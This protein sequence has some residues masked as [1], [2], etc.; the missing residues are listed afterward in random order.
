MAPGEAQA[1]QRQLLRAAVALVVIV[2]VAYWPSLRHDF[3]RLD[4][5]QYVVDNEVVRH[6]SLSGAWLFF[7]EVT[8]PSTVAG[9]YQPLTMVSLMGDVLLA[10]SDTPGPLVFHLTNVL[11]H[12]ATS[13]LVLL[14]MR[15]VVGGIAI[16]LLVAVLFAIHPVQV[17]SVS[18]ISQRKTVL[19]SFFAVGCVLSY[20]RYGQTRRQTAWL[21]AAVVLYVVAGL[22]KPTVML[23]PLVLPLLDLWPLN[24]RVIRSLP[25]K[26]PFAVIMLVMSWVAWTSQVASAS[27]HKPSV[28][29]AG[30]LVKWIGLLSYNIMLYAG[31]VL[32]PLSLS[33]YRA[34]P[35]DPTPANPVVALA[36]V[37]TITIGLIW[38]ASMR[39]CRPLFVGLT[40]FGIILLP[41]LGAVRFM[42]SCVADRF[43]YLPLVFLLLPLAVLSARIKASAGQRKQM[44]RVGLVLFAIPLL[45]LMRAQ[46]G[47]WS[48]SK[49]LWTHS[50]Q[51]VPTLLKAHNNLAQIYLEEES[52]DE[53]L[54]H[55]EECLRQDPQRGDFLHMLGRIR[56]RQ[57][58]Q[59]EAVGVIEAA[60]ENGLGKFEGAGYVSLAEAHVAR[61]DANAAR[62][63]CEKAIGCGRTPAVSFASIGDVALRYAGRYELAIE[64]YRFAVDDDPENVQYRWNLG[65]ALHACGRA[66]EAL[67][68]YDEAIA[69]AARQGRHLPKLQAAAR[70]LR[71]Q[72][73]QTATSSSGE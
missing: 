6:P 38:I 36:V 15:S 51:S 23:L 46:Q 2:L 1:V 42:G 54:E 22:A 69:I 56:V 60:I 43:L 66:D 26:L 44:I 57:G 71:Q 34:L 12:A 68:E 31:N 27:L 52:F 73:E 10:G 19:A 13:V 49:A 41:A 7:S 72:V 11:L 45:I 16:P 20:L 21:V 9:Y 47:V 5:Y 14:L 18:W 62:E 40:S 59:D 8:E 17:E 35:D 67:E 33:P 63:A 48:N 64:Y 32:W 39:W 53:A 4:D 37:G 29:D 70:K 50:A 65:T 55:V 61:G 25:E 28:A 24:R 3:V 58:R 30:A